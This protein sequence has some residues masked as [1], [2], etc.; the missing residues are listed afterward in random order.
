VLLPERVSVPVPLF[1]K[2]LLRVLSVVLFAFSPLNKISDTVN[3]LLLAKS[4]HIP[5][6]LEQIHEIYNEAELALEILGSNNGICSN[7]FNFV[8]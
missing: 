7:E 6:S 4:N 1:D 2:P 5:V 3:E 8:F